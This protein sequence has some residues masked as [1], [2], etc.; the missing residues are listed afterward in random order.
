MAFQNSH[1]DLGSSEAHF[2]QGS[3][4]F[5]SFLILTR[6]WLLLISLS[7]SNK[8]L[9]VCSIGYF[10]VS[11]SLFKSYSATTIKTVLLYNFVPLL[12]SWRVL[13]E[14]NNVTIKHF[15]LTSFW[16]SYVFMPQN[17]FNYH[18]NYTANQCFKKLIC[19]YFM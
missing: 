17:K 9:I 1:G 12:G 8:R 5:F 16:Q 19:F 3:Y 7:Y 10:Q 14:Q 4:F 15:C 11:P 13:R 18:T 2:S 6:E